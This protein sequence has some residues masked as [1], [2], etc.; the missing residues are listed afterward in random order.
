M[1]DAAFFEDL[2]RRL[3]SLSCLPQRQL[4][5]ANA[6]EIAEL[7]K[8]AGAPLPLVYREFLRRMGRWAG[9]LF[10]GSDYSLEQWHHLRLREHAERILRKRHAAYSLPTAAFVFLL[11]QGYQFL[12]FSLDDGDDPPAF[13]FSEKSGTVEQKSDSF[14]AFLDSF[15]RDLEEATSKHHSS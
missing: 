1:V 8:Y 10:L 15:V 11:H 2:E 4:E 7:E 9:E 3:Q 6:Q 12:F 5:G 14:S 13:H